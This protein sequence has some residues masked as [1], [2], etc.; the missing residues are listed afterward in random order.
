MFTETHQKITADH[1]RRDAFLYV[2]QSTLRQVFENTE[3]ADRQYALRDRAV[4]LGWPIERIHII[5]QDLGISGAHAQNRDGFQH[6]VTEVAMGHAGIV[7][8]LEVSRLARNNADWQR[9][10]ELAALS[11]TLILDLDG[12]YDPAHFNDRLL[13]GLKGTMS[14]AELHILKARLQGG[15]LNKAR[16]GELEVPLPIGFVYD[17]TGAVAL[18]PDQQIQDS[19]RLLL[20]TYRQTRS[21]CQ[22]VRRFRREALL[23]PRRIRR[24]VGKGDVHWAALENS[25]VTQILHNPCYAGAFA[26]GR[27]RVIHSADYQHHQL[28]VAQEN[29]KVLIRDAHVGYLDWEEFDRNQVT[30][31]QHAGGFNAGVRGRMPREG[32]A[33]LQGRVVCGLCGARMRVR[34]QRVDEHLAPYY[35]C[36]EDVVRRAG[37]ACQSIRGRDIDA[38]ISTLLLETVA[39]AALEVAL[40]VQDEIA[41]RIEAADTLRRSQLE[42]ARYEAELKRRRFLKCDPDHRLVADALEAD[43]NE[44]LRRL[45]TLQQEH[46]HQRNADQGLLGDAARARI[47]ALAHDFPRVWNDSRTDPRERKRM[48]ALLIEDVTLIK[49]ERIA[50][51]VRFR[52]GQN[53]SL[54]LDRPVPIA[55]VRKTRP[56]VIHKLDDLLETSSDREAAAQLNVLGFANWKREAFTAKRV[57][58]VRQIYGLKSR[59]DRLRAKGFLTAGEIAR[60]LGVCVSM[61][62]KLGCGGVLP[63][64]RYGN[65]QR[66]LYNPL[67][68]AVY[69]RGCGGRYRPTPPKLMPGPSSK[70][71]IV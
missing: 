56:A 30:L 60:E 23:F 9:L 24:G 15:M 68:G 70:Q 7:L 63:R 38:A 14:E 55:R 19:I 49:A 47:L 59:F 6:L 10:L 57:R 36:T 54:S 17:P 45:D 40:A 44:Q 71:E 28:K 2:R 11:N 8:G 20:D 33:L 62:H 3:S 42:R 52:G 35:F 37:T 51:H 21:A 18:D 4:A 32:T 46:E 34:Y 27:T 67:N 22:V 58:Y 50:V 16:R 29:W 66:C 25:R 39:P 65:D 12:V 64:Q 1:L 43:W 53:T 41:S 61:V 69:V 13:L 5:D 26:Y 48:L 31:R